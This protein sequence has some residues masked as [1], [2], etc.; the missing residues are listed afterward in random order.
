MSLLGKIGGPMLKDNLER[1]GVDL[2]VQSGLLYFDVNNLR[3][4][5]NNSLPV[6]EFDLVGNA[7]FDS[8]LKISG[9]TITSENTN[10]N[11]TVDPN[12]SGL[13]RV[14][15][16]NSNSVLLAGSSGAIT[17]S[18]N[19]T[20]STD[21]LTVISSNIGDL[22]LSNNTIISTTTNSNITLTPNGI[23]VVVS[24]SLAVTDLIQNRIVI[25]GANGRLT[26]NANLTFDGSNLV[27][28]GDTLLSS[29]QLGNIAFSNTTIITSL[30]NS[31][32][33][34]QA[35]GSGNVL[36]DSAK[37]TGTSI[38]SILIT[39]S[40]NLITT[41]SELR[42]NAST[43]TL[44]IGNIDIASND[45]EAVNSNGNLSLTTNGS[46]AIL[47]NSTS[48]LKLPAGTS[49]ERP[50]IASAGMIRW[51]TT[52]GELEYYNGVTWDTITTS[53]TNVT[54]DTFSGDDSTLTFTLSQSATTASVIVSINGVLQ[55]PTTAYTV[56]GTILTFTEAPLS[57][58]NIEARTVVTLVS[59]TSISD[60]DTTIQVNDSIPSIIANVNGS[61]ALTL[62]SSAATF[63]GNII[64]TGSLASI[65]NTTPA[66]SSA[67]GTKG[68]IA[69]DS[70][71]IYVCVAANTWV[72]FAI[73]TSF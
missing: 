23:G 59:V 48:T 72:K 37:I 45:I 12:G 62:S 64:G 69:Y 3:L 2:T 30:T 6:V 4:G 8:N 32:L 55:K 61:T 13:L 46:G 49:G 73:T 65:V 50:D 27:I 10:G 11:I 18:S 15:Y 36:I 20:F 63:V 58:D 56:S 70:S 66:S 31:D 60:G 25:V 21:T 53:I 51:N 39:D 35:N 9:T 52:N 7:L 57:T 33:N 16:L 44:S 43:N 24:S 26:D 1:N 34:L 42:Y 19:I 17:Q 38:N 47:L 28:N 5:I 40:S 68:Q 54:S 67:A 14:S 41:D 71:F 29:A 22:R